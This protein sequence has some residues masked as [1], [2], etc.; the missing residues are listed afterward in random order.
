M[1][2]TPSSS[3]APPGAAAA[4][5]PGPLDTVTSDARTTGR[6]PPRVS[7]SPWGRLPTGVRR[8]LV[9]AILLVGWQAY[10]SLAEVSPLLFASPLDVGRALVT[11]FA[12]GELLSSTATT[13]QVLLLSMLIGM[14]IAAVLT[15]LAMWTTFGDDLL[16]VLTSMLNPLPSIAILPMA[17][18]WFGINDK[19]LVFV[20]TN[21]VVWP[22]GINVSIGFRTINN[23]V[24]SVGRN[25][26]LNRWRMISEVLVPAALPHTI[27]GLKTAWAFGWRTIIAA[28]LV[29]GAAGGKGGLGYFINVS[30]LYLNIPSALAGMVTIAV[31]G[32]LIEVAFTWIERR[33]VIRWGMKV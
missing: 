11:D 8:L 2:P 27:A 5:A 12:S 22:I 19:A 30:R 26:G 33:T 4:A 6:R 14:G 13:M 25:I 10:V 23:T 20:V 18:L 32:I 28:E 24:L 29:F 17:M 16:S 3:K 31:I 15:T 1:K 7:R 9:V 21:A